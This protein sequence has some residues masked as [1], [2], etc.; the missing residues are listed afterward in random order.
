MEYNLIAKLNFLFPWLVLNF[1]E[2][3]FVKI[4][5]LCHWYQPPKSLCPKLLFFW[6]EFVT[7]LKETIEKKKSGAPN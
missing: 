6:L 7:W 2:I 4:W 5:T 1:C 3:D